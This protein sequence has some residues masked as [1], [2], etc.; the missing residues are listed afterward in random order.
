[1]LFIRIFAHF[2]ARLGTK[3]SIEYVAFIVS[4]GIVNECALICSKERFIGEKLAFSQFDGASTKTFS[5][6]SVK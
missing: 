2:H 6:S 1:M 5:T 4:K 3:D